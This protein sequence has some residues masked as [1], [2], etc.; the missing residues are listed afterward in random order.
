MAWNAKHGVKNAPVGDSASAKLRVDHELAG[1]AGVRHS[2]ENCAAQ[3]EVASDQWSVTE[4]NQNWFASLA[5]SHC[6]LTTAFSL[7]ASAN[8]KVE[9][10]DAVLISG[11]DD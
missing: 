1:N 10:D 3:S 5:T 2:N 9:A 8:L 7:L 11:S 4:L 6:S